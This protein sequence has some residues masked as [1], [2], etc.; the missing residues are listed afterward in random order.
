MQPAILVKGRRVAYC[1]PGRPDTGLTTLERGFVVVCDG[2]YPASFA[3]Q[4]EDKYLLEDIVDV[5]ASS[6]SY[7]DM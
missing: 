6:S 1:Q 7:C 2:G 4:S 3:C 5:F